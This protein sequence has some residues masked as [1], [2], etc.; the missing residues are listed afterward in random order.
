MHSL[1]KL[2]VALLCCALGCTLCSSQTVLMRDPSWGHG[3]APKGSDSHTLW[4]S[5]AT[6]PAEDPTVVFRRSHSHLPIVKPQLI[7]RL[8]S[9]T[10]LIDEVQQ[11]LAGGADPEES[12]PDGRTAL[13][14][15][16][17]RGHKHVT[18][19]LLEHGADV[20]AKAVDGSTPLLDTALTGREAP[21][22]LLL[23]YGA[24][25]SVKNP[26]GQTPLH[27][28]ALQGREAVVRLLLK[29]GAV[30]SAKAN[31]GSTPLDLATANSHHRI[32]ALLRAEATRRARAKFQRQ[33]LARS[34]QVGWTHLP[35]GN[36]GAKR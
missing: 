9:A 36:P 3:H 12:G 25:I 14:E 21:A 4:Y 2:S 23:E 10:G 28:A 16:A 17:A 32:A 20:S 11:L 24:D 8:S 6:G 29:L 5:T 33:P 27:V 22:R 35:G 13:H 15:A 18:R 26:A 7:L 30:L 1:M 31:D 19:M 34:E